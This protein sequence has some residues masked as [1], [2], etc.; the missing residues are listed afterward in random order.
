MIYLVNRHEERIASGLRPKCVQEASKAEN[1]DEHQEEEL[2]HHGSQRKHH[3][4]I[5]QRHKSQPEQRIV[6]GTSERPR[7][8]NLPRKK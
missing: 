7:E 5:L 6:Q 4:I 1:G 2:R 3:Q 8:H